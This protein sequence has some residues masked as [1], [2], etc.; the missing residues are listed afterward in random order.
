MTLVAM[1][2]EAD[3]NDADRILAILD[4]TETDVRVLEGQDAGLYRRR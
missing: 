4:K 2:S 1:Q 3:L